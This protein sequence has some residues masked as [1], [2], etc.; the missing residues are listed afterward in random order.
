MKIDIPVNL[1]AVRRCIMLLADTN[2]VTVSRTILTWI[3]IH[4][5]AYDKC[6][7]IKEDMSDF[8][9]PCGC[10][11]DICTTEEDNYFELSKRLRM[12]F[13]TLSTT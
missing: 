9:Y 4:M 13:H 12:F 8:T 6:G 3:T 7:Y 5:G 10:V 2:V 1:V 11:F